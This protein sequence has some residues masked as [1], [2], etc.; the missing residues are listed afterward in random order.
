MREE[1]AEI[2][3]SLDERHQML[4]LQVLRGVLEMQQRDCAE[5]EA[6]ER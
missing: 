4:A 3:E 1:L 2:F 5:K 6:A